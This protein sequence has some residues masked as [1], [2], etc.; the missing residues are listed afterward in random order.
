MSEEEGHFFMDLVSNKKV[1]DMPT[2]ELGYGD[3]SC[4]HMFCLETAQ[5]IIFGSFMGGRLY[6]KF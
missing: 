5:M 6:R 4:M 2:Y 1:A 3:V